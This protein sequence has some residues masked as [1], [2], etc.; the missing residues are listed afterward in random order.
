[1]EMMF[2]G[3]VV[4][5]PKRNKKKKR[6]MSA[7]E[8]SQM[9]LQD[10][11]AELICRHMR[12]AQLDG[13]NAMDHGTGVCSHVLPCDCSR[14]VQIL[15]DCTMG[16]DTT[17]RNNV[18]FRDVFVDCRPR[19]KPNTILFKTG[20]RAVRIGFHNRNDYGASEGIPEACKQ[21]KAA[22]AS[23]P[24]R[25]LSHCYMGV[26]AFAAFQRLPLWSWI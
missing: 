19:L 3:G 17:G 4:S 13:L 12:A 8:A 24:T 15:E 25:P 18:N 11:M 7:G 21:N 14:L 22:G 10:G 1:M 5:T 26:E 23:S 6:Y 9:R 2:D 20:N 16:S